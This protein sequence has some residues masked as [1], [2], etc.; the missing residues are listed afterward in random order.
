MEHTT[1]KPISLATHAAI[2]PFAGILFIAAPWIFGFQDVDDATTIC[3][4]LGVAVLLTGMMTR[5]RM[6]IV[7]LIPL[8]VHRAMDLLVGVVAIAAPFAFGFSDIGGPSRFLIIMGV[9]ELGVALLTRWDP[10]D[11]FA[12]VHDRPPRRASPTH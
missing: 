2:E 4:V 10:A 12:T 9:A 8:Q 7:K 3:V 6:A 11:D 5:W 1:N